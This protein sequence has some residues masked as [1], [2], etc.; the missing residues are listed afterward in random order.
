[1]PNNPIYKNTQ[2]NKY[3]RKSTPMQYIQVH[4]KQI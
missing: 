2:K 1:M 4:T 3:I